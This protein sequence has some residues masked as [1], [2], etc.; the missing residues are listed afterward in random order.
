MRCL[1]VFLTVLII[2]IGIVQ[3]PKAAISD[4]DMTISHIR[5]RQAMELGGQNGVLRGSE[6]KRR[7]IAQP[8]AILTAYS[9]TV[10]QT[11]DRPCEAADGSDICTRWAKGEGICATNDYPFGTRLFLGRGVDQECTVADRM[12]RRF[13]GKHKIDVYFG[14]RTKEAWAF[15]V[16]RGVPVWIATTE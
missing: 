1:S 5:E 4:V 9:S 15:G 3:S 13:T 16:K 7:L 6:V 11:D 8:E 12:A 14:N 10:G 2:P